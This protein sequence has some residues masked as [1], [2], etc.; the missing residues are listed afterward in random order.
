MIKKQGKLAGFFRGANSTCRTHIRKHYEFYSQKCEEKKIK[1]NKR[2]IPL[3]I[4]RVREKAAAGKG[5]VQTQLDTMLTV[6][7]SRKEFSREAIL[8]AVTE[9]V[10]CTD[11]GSDYS[12][13]FSQ[14]LM[15]PSTDFPV[16]RE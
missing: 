12:C 1:E 7:K 16:Y 11:M 4:A 15:N 3:E 9:L 2:C 6:D 14:L 8:K 10:A 13:R 5:M